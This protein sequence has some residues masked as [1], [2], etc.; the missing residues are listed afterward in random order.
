MFTTRPEI[1]GTFGVVTSTH[2]LASMAGWSMLE[3]GGNAFD[4]AVATGFALQVVEPHQ[5]G[6]GGDLPV[7]LYNAAKGKVEVICGQGVSPAAATIDR[8]GA[9]GVNTIPGNGLLAACVPGAF[10]GWLLLLRDH[11]T[12]ALADVMAPAIGY[13]RDGYA[14]VPALNETITQMAGTFTADWPTSAATYL[15]GNDAPAVGSLHA[16]PTLAATYERLVQEAEA[17]SGSREDKIEAARSAYY[18]GFVAAAIDK[19]C[20]ETEWPDGTG[21]SN[22]GLLTGHDMAAWRATAEA[23]VTYDYHGLTVC[24]PGPWSQAPVLLQQL[25]LL[26]GFPL[27]EM[28]PLGPDFVHT[29]VEA[30]KL[31]LADREAWYG[32]PNTTDVPMAALLSDTYNDDRRTLM[33]STASLEL[34]PGAPAGRPPVLP[35]IATDSP[36]LH[37]GSLP[38]GSGEPNANLADPGD[39]VHLDAADRF[40]NMVSCMPSGGWLQSSP[41]IPSLGFCLGTRL[42]MFWLQRGLA[43]SLAPGARPRTTLSPSLA[44]RDGAAVLAFGTPGGDQQDQWALTTFLRHIHHGYD[45][46]AA[47]DAPTYHTDHAPSSFYPRGAFPGVLNVEGRLPAATVAELKRR[48]HRIQV[49]GDWTLGRMTA[50]ARDQIDGRMILK[51]AAHPRFQQAYAIGR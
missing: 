23:P 42:Q 11:G 22:G 27:A 31:A 17:K 41:I 39:T 15:V 13:A 14:V 50:V 25:A 2:W 3:R 34:R 29:Q 19:F 43:S 10:A 38:V 45:L 16:N 18:E 49:V 40:G 36:L 26:Q 4:A 47:C 12:L 21:N 44:L 30:A 46:Q 20:R 1:R 7:I 5:N 33:T 9:L 51:A 24:K 28:D 48:G 8:F 32:D 6:L 37:D 35:D